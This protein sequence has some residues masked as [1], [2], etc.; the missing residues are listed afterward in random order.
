MLLLGLLIF[1]PNYALADNCSSLS[2]CY[3]TLRAALAAT[4]GL[5]TLAVISLI[6]DLLP[7]VG[8]LK[9]LYEVAGGEDPVTGEELEGWMRVVAG[10]GV[11]PIAGNIVKVG[12]K[13]LGKGSSIIKDARSV[14]TIPADRLNAAQKKIRNY[15]PPYTAGT[16]V[17]QVVT[18]K[19]TKLVRVRAEN[20]RNASVWLMNPED[21]R[22]LS[23]QEIKD[24]YA[25]PAEM[26]IKYIVEVDIPAGTRM[27]I[28]EV[29]PNK[30]GK[31][32]ATQYEVKNP[33]LPESAFG[34]EQPIDDF[35]N[36]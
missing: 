3:N 10:I 25:I 2:D 14:I 19:P 9:S 31:G 8:N 7:G 4:V 23:K 22:G 17:I 36:K 11:I 20:G 34:K 15:D 30:Y 29:A 28:G 1:F 5:T 16:K 21:L 6:L 26:D 32:G 35:L 13:V 24:R 33:Y 18:G 27:H 12:G